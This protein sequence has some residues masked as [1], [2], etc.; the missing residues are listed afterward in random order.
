M[1]SPVGTHY[2]ILGLSRSATQAE[3]EDQYRSL[4]KVVHPDAGGDAIMFEVLHESYEVLADPK[5]RAAY[6][7]MLP[8]PAPPVLRHIVADPLPHSGGWLQPSTPAQ[9]ERAAELANEGILSWHQTADQRRLA[10]RVKAKWN[11]AGLLIGAVVFII[12]RIA[13]GGR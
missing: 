6:D 1:E 7:R 10:R 2:D 5:A 4:A 12:W 3:I 8:A 11:A 9:R 13:G